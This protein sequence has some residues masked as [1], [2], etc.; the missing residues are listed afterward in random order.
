MT[1][2][3]LLVYQCQKAFEILKDA[4]VK[5]PILVYPDPNK[6]YTLFTDASNMLGLPC[7]HRN[8]LL[9]LM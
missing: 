8:T 4:H 2:T 9:L 1:K 5:S 3:T 7:S 6:P